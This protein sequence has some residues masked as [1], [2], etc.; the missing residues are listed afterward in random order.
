MELLL[1]GLGVGLL[2]G[3]LWG[4]RAVLRHLGEFEFRNRWRAVKGIR[5]W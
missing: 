4:R 2:A 5:R 1:I 3:R